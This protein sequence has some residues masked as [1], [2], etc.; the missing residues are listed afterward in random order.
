MKV[1]VSFG[2]SV[3]IQNFEFLRF[4]VS[5]EEDV[6]SDF[7]TEYIKQAF[8]EL[9][10]YVYDEI[11][12][13]GRATREP[14]GIAIKNEPIAE[15]A[16]PKET[17]IESSTIVFGTLQRQSDSGKAELY[18][19]A[20]GVRTTWIPTAVIKKRFEDR[21]ELVSESCLKYVKWEVMKQK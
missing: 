4:D 5:T 13:F 3:N 14:P 18:L 20:D 21:I 2:K 11:A 8:A 16:K 7:R 9:K 15:P 10:N 6:D 19:N 12:E 1:R 17:T